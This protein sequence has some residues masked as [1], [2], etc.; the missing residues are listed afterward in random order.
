MHS[1]GTIVQLYHDCIESAGSQD[2]MALGIH[3]LVHC[4]NSIVQ[5]FFLMQF[6]AEYMCIM[7]KRQ[8]L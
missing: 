7:H 6:S 8:L 5:A 3:Q 1:Y 2:L 4:N